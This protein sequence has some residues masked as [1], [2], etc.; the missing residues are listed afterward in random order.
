LVNK[1]YVYADPVSNTMT[2]GSHGSCM[3]PGPHL[4]R[5]GVAAG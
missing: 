3:T 1:V 5:E 2:T 4:S